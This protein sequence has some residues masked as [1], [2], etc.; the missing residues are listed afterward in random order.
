VCS[1]ELQQKN[2]KLLL[3]LFEKVFLVL[4]LRKLLFTIKICLLKPHTLWL[5]F[6]HPTFNIL[7]LILIQINSKLY[8]SFS[9]SFKVNAKEWE[10]MSK[11]ALFTVTF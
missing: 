4:K 7:N 11:K 3:K 6:F 10:Q 9:N 2:T 1:N 5:L 8:H